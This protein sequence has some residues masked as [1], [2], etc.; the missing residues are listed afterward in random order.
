[1]KIAST[2]AKS[3]RQASA[4]KSLSTLALA[5]MGVLGVAAPASAVPILGADLASFAVLGATPDVTN[6]PTSTIVGNVG[7]SPAQAFSGF[8]FVA[9]T[10][11]ADSQVTGGSVH[12][13]TALAQSA[14]AELTTARGILSGLGV[15]TLL[16]A[17]L[18]GLTIFPGVFTVP[19]A[20]TNLS[21][22]VT[23]D[24]L[25]D[26]NAFWLF[27]TGALT[28]ASG[29][30]VNVINT[31]ASGGA[32]VFWNDTSSVI[33]GSTTSFQGNIL[34]LTSI[35]LITKATIG[36]GRALAD[37]GTVILDQNT[38]N[39][40]TCTGTGEEGSTGLRGSGLEFVGG[41][42]FDTAADTFVNK[43]GTFVA[44]P[45]AAVPEPGSLALFG[46]ALAGLFAF[47]KRLFPV[48]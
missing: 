10:A 16:P 44:G 32:G 27:Q 23:L 7:V 29:S 12:S 5:V 42:V 20:T 4:A 6:V 30:V 36:C 22:A 35:T 18:T 33:L 11:T 2:P 3:T 26:P 38:I 41:G 46:L 34:A 1:M 17:D 28:T 25:G 15:G 39:A 45:I 9:G 14:Q 21:G 40:I 13:N 24:G 19:F 47:R 37:T 48:A 43:P 8:N 31:G